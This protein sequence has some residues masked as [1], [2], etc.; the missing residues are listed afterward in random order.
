MRRKILCIL[1]LIMAMV[2]GSV[3]G[4]SVCSKQDEQYLRQILKETWAYLDSHLAKETGFPTDSQNAGGNTNTTNIGLYLAAIGPAQKMGFI[5]RT[6][7]LQRIHKI[8][9]S[10]EKIE[11][12]NGFLYN[13]IDVGGNTKMPDGVMAVSDFN[14]LITG[15]ILVRQFFP[16]IADKASPLIQRVQWGRLF[17][18][19]SGN[20]YWGYDLK[21][22]KL[23][24]LGNFWLAS[25][26]RLVMFYMIASGSAPAEIWDKAKCNKIHADALTF[27]EPGYWFGGLFMQ[28]MDAMFL[29]SP[30]T[31]EMGNSIADFA[32]HQ[33]RRSQDRG[34]KV[35]GWS[36]CNIPGKGYTEGGF[37]PWWI[38]TPHASAL[39]IEY[40][41][42]HVIENLRRL[43]AIGLRK[44]LTTDAANYGFRDS[45]DLITGKADDRYLSLDQAMIFLSLTNFLEQGM[46]RKSFTNDPLVK[47][48]FKLLGTR[49]AQDPNL[50]EKWAKRDASEPQPL[51]QQKPSNFVLDMKHPDGCILNSNAAGGSKV[52]S[53]FTA[54]GLVIDFTTGD[55]QSSEINTD[56]TFP[57]IDL[58]N[59][60]S[61]QIK[62][63]GRSKDALGGIRLYLYDDQGQSQYTYIDSLLPEMKEFNIPDSSILGMLAKPDAVNKLT[64]KLWPKPW[65]YT[66]QNT[67]AKSG[68]IVIEKITFKQ[69]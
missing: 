19:A 54:E 21:N 41:P 68:I 20:T 24:G 15:L 64:I 58:R 28:A 65:F 23:I 36:N 3:F 6:D 52:D 32:W 9:E 33:I 44:P 39:V 55:E 63:C 35:W 67:K 31:K 14:K 5:T 40:Y 49:L 2:C 25:D 4:N 50:P 17:D 42:R 45:I 30:A 26:C 48:G 47:N 43:D 8:I 56:I 10:L 27:Y 53:K 37:L 69:K 46:I 16:E 57:Q 22:D 1:G 18:T 62:C 66:N 12:R 7:A 29:D 38:V 51:S 13:W 59:L 60:D 34:L 61:I 11:S